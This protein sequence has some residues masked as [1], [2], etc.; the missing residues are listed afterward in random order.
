MTTQ[1]AP[2]RRYV[3]A[4]DITDLSAGFLTREL[5]PGVFMISNGNY[6][7][8]FLTTGEGVVLLDAP[9]PLIAHLSK[10]IADVTDERLHTLV[11]S[12][13]HSDHI[14]GAHMFAHEGVAI[15]AE[16][17]TAHFLA[18]KNDPARPLPTIVFA[19]STTLQIGDRRIELTRDDFH[20]AG[21]DTVLY[22]PQEKVLV[23]IDLLA[24]GW[25]PLLDFDLTEN[26]YSY[27]NAF[28][29]FLSYDFVHFLSG[30]T[31]D[32]A[33]RADV[34]LTQ[35]YVHD[36]Y[37]TVKRLHDEISTPELLEKHR[38]NEQAGIK[39]TIEE[40]VGRATVELSER[41]ADGPMKGV[42]LWTESHARAMTLYVRWTD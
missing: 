11:Y 21:G 23:A 1:T 40:V 29:R 20:T 27:M 42:E 34:E 41:W 39:W 17:G 32:V 18:E 5:T 12:H 14:G 28:G 10:A 16:E 3:Q 35:R 13:G 9:V 6:Q 37:E 31:A 19:G 25:V 24:H 38:D 22:L 36:V 4:P 7:T 8:L 15:V 33:T 2:Q 26:V 30:H